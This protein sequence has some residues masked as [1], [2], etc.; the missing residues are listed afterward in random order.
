MFLIAYNTYSQKWYN[1]FGTS[2]HNETNRDITEAYDNGY[3]VSGSYKI[4]TPSNWLIKTDINGNILWDK[5]I[6]HDLLEVFSGYL[7]QNNSGEIA[8]GRCLTYDNGDQWPMVLKLDSCGDKLWCREFIDNNYSHGWF[9]DIICL[10][11]GDVLALGKLFSIENYNERIFLYY[12]DA[13]GNLIWRESYASKEDHPLVLERTGDRI[14]KYSNEYI[15]S[16]DCYYPYPGN[17]G[18]GYMRPFYIGIDNEFKEKWILP[19]GVND[20]II[21]SAF[22]L[23]PLNDSVY[24]GVGFKWETGEDQNS[25]LMFFNGDGEEL[26]I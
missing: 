17:P 12:I 23:I 3:L 10:D 13:N 2:N 1:F 25:I 15:I 9:T 20:S 14:H 16:G 4:P 7:D 24:M 22:N 8:I 11:N 21:G 6:L 5:V 18:T 19:F 26:G